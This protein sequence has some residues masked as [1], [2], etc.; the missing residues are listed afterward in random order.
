MAE[1][2]FKPLTAPLFESVTGKAPAVTVKGYAACLRGNPV[3][4]FGL[5]AETERMVLFA[6]ILPA[7]RSGGFAMRRAFVKAAAIVRRMLR[8]TIAPVHCLADPTVTN[9]GS[10]LAYIGM[11]EIRNGVWSWHR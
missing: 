11:K 6:D 4:V 2:E 7:A 5:R 3:A 1:Y 8:D 9:S 10:F